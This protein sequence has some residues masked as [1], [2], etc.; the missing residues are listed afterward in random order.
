TAPRQTAAVQTAAAETAGLQARQPG[1]N[2]AQ[3]GA[4]QSLLDGGPLT[5]GEPVAGRGEDWQAASAGL[6]DLVEQAFRTSQPDADKAPE[7]GG[8][9]HG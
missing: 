9:K 4:G 1:Q 8:A 5:L 7:Q 6:A 3:P 2:A